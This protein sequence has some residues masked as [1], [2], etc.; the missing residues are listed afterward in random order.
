MIA[1][2][3]LLTCLQQPKPPGPDP[4]TKIRKI[5]DQLDRF[6]E[7]RDQFHDQIKDLRQ[8]VDEANSAVS[9]RDARN[10]A[11]QGLIKEKSQ[12]ITRPWTIT[13][14]SRSTSSILTSRG[15]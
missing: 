11:L 5:Q 9:V 8:Q 15:L 4:E 3:Y 12:T 6:Q 10:K 14:S 7:E 13:L 2:R 1:Q